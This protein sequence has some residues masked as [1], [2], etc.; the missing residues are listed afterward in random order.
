MLNRNIANA[1]QELRTATESLVPE[2]QPLNL[3]RMEAAVAQRERAVARLK[4]LAASGGEEFTP[5]DLRCVQDS[6]ESG[7]RS[8]EELLAI[9]RRGWMKAVP[10]LGPRAVTLQRKVTL[11]Q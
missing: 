5:E 7:R 10:R 9:R 4:Q 3:D 2:G 8:R 6:H 11:I 1:L